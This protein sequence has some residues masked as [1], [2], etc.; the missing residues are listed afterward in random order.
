[1]A[2]TAAKEQGRKRSHV[3]RRD[4]AEARKAHTQDTHTHTHTRHTVGSLERVRVAL[5]KGGPGAALVLPVPMRFGRGTRGR[6]GRRDNVHERAAGRL[7]RRGWQRG[8]EMTTAEREKASRAG[9]TR[10]TGGD[11][12]VSKQTCTLI[13]TCRCRCTKGHEPTVKAH[14]EA[15]IETHT[16]TEGHRDTRKPKGKAYTE[17][18]IETHTEG[19]RGTRKGVDSGVEIVSWPE[20]RRR[21][22]NH[23]HTHRSCRHRLRSQPR[24]TTTITRNHSL[25]QTQSHKSQTQ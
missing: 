1:M 8:R 9:A 13:H 21:S 2:S 14:T 3:D 12:A 10:G 17:A 22:Q 16:H 18:Y 19:H 25:T 7:R 6:R 4:T 23:R 5:A 11:G 24:S 15:Y 20:R